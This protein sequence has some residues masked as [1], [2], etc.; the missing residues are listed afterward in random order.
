LDFESFENIVKLCVGLSFTPVDRQITPT[1]LTYLK[2][3]TFWI[4]LWGR[5]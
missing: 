5:Q 4:K 3:V 1:F 2:T